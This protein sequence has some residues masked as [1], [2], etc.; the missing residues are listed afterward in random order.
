MQ[1]NAF[2]VGE[3]HGVISADEYRK[4][5]IDQ[6]EQT[7]YAESIR[8]GG[9]FE[10]VLTPERSDQAWSAAILTQH[11]EVDRFKSDSYFSTLSYS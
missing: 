3:L 6:L 1:N 2:V 8:T 11:R 9:E 10:D 5:V 7:Q 4:K